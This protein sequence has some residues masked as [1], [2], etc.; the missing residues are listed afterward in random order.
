VTTVFVTHDQEEA[1]SMSDRI[2][3]M[4]LGRIEQIGTPE[5]LYNRPRTTF[6]AGFIGSSNLLPGRIESVTGSDVTVAP[7]GYPMLVRATNTD[8]GLAVGQ[9]V[10]V[11]VRPER[12]DV[13][14]APEMRGANS[15][16]GRI[17]FTTYVG[18]VTK[19][20]IQLDS[21]LLMYA[22]IPNLAEGIRRTGEE[23]HVSWSPHDTVIIATET[24]P[25]AAMSVG[26]Q[27]YR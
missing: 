3:V 20:S 9:A 13:S 10:H 12:M 19:Y 14:L 25:M 4:N 5:E 26:G 15:F 1:M 24:E 11:L 8:Q 16:H 2:A 22:E 7:D 17:E 18:A 23:V 6:V 27:S 21:G